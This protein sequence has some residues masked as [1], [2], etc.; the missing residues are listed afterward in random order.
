MKGKTM[1]LAVEMFLPT[2]LYEM[3]EAEGQRAIAGGADHPDQLHDARG[4][5]CGGASRFRW[6]V[7]VADPLH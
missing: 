7:D 5:F 6:R 2:A 4:P 3:R 1:P